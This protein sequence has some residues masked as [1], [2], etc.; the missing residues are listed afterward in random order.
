MLMLIGM[1]FAVGSFPTGGAFAKNVRKSNGDETPEFRAD[2]ITPGKTQESQ[3]A[4]LVGNPLRV[5]HDRGRALYFYDVGLSGASMTAHIAVRRGIVESMT[6]FCGE[7]LADA[8]KKYGAFQDGRVALSGVKK[9]SLR[10]GLRQVVFESA[11]RAFLFSPR[12]DA[13]RVCVQWEPGKKLSEVG[14]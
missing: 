9:T 7:K 8:F 1:S 5:L 2:L 12:S 11:G 6:Y 14:R 3:L 10:G 4:Q 13:A